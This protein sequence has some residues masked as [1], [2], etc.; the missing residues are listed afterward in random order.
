MAGKTPFS[1]WRKIAMATWHT[2]NDPWITAEMDLDARK[3]LDYISDVRAATGAHVTMMHLVGRAGAKVIEALPVLNGRVLAGRYIPS[4]TI[5]VFFT[6][7]LNAEVTGDGQAASATDL[8]GA[9]IRRVNEKTPWQIAREL[10]GK[11]RRIRAGRDPMFRISKA[12]SRV[13]PPMVLRAFLAGTTLVT[14]DLQI[15]LPLLGLEARPFGS[16]LVTNIGS[17]GLDRAFPPMPTM[18]HTSVGVAVGAVRQVPVVDADGNIVARPMLP[19]AAGIDHRYI[20]GY[21]AALIA[22]VFRQYME[23]PARFD[24]VPSRLEVARAEGAVPAET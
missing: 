16:L 4:P 5:D 18:C 21:Q 11:A 22:R 23:D 10:D 13:L 6:V 15:P 8:S 19:V 1:Q 7:S 20:D 12:I 14:E 17:F 9:V 3:A 2:R 24:P